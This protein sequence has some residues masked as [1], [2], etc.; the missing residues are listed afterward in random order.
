MLATQVEAYIYYFFSS[1]IFNLELN[2]NSEVEILV[3][4]II[5]EQVHFESIQSIGKYNNQIDLSD[6]SKGIYNLTIKTSDT[7][8]NHKLILQ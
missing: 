7:I 2:I 3:T 1:N 5:G 6:S 4:N 8:S